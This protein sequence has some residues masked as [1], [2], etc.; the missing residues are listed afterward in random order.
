MQ[1][2]GFTGAIGVAV[3]VVLGGWRLLRLQ[4]GGRLR[5]SLREQL[6][7][8]ASYPLRLLSFLLATAGHMTAT[9]A[10]VAVLAAESPSGDTRARVPV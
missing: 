2:S 1:I 9:A 6:A 8:K 10:K 4:W 7:R 3:G 5:F